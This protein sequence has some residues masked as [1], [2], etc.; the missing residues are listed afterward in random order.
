MQNTTRN[1]HNSKMTDSVY[2][3]YFQQKQQPR[4]YIQN[5]FRESRN[6]SEI[7]SQ[8][9][10]RQNE[11]RI[12]N[13]ELAQL[14]RRPSL[15]STRTQTSLSRQSSFSQTSTQPKQ[16]QRPEVIEFGIINLESSIIGLEHEIFNLQ[17]EY[18]QTRV[19][20][21]NKVH[22]RFIK[23]FM[24]LWRRQEQ[25]GGEYKQLMNELPMS[26]EYTTS[27]KT[28]EW[29]SG[30]SK[31]LWGL[32]EQVVEEHRAYQLRKKEEEHLRMI[33]EY[34]TLRSQRNYVT[35]PLESDFGSE[36]SNYSTEESNFSI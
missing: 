33:E 22:K 32:K 26:H 21:T 25:I 6:V 20:I 5:E 13:A 36:M 17:E 3:T 10:L 28:K 27:L 7:Q 19:E 15:N 24:F 31:R 16:V 1:R 29:L 8:T 2:Q 35:S 18:T 30:L 4:I 12:K 34:F 23:K 11:L 14:R 9:F